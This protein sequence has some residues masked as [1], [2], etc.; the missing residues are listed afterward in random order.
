[1]DTLIARF[2]LRVDFPL[3]ELLEHYQQALRDHS[4]LVNGEREFEARRSEVL[5]L[6]GE[7]GAVEGIIDYAQGIFCLEKRCSKIFFYCRVIA[8]R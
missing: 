6:A 3:E 1:M 2:D 5:S 4:N 7:T 8:A